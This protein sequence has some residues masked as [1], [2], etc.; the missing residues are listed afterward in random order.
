MVVTGLP[1]AT[2][3]TTEQAQGYREHLGLLS[4][5]MSKE[6]GFPTS[7]GQ[8]GKHV[9]RGR[10]AATTEKQRRVSDLIFG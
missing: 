3:S 9:E 10:A 8:L 1:L 6:W 2:E 7:T 4:S 5:W